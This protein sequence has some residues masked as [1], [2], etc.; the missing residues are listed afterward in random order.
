M[1]TIKLAFILLIIA[2]SAVS[3]EKDSRPVQEI[4]KTEDWSNLIVFGDYDDYG[5]HYDDGTNYYL[6]RTS[7]RDCR[8]TDCGTFEY[9]NKLIKKRRKDVVDLQKEYDSLKNKAESDYSKLKDKAKQ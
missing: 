5:Y 3:C 8:I 2:F 9:I 7:Y 6:L 1:K 4:E